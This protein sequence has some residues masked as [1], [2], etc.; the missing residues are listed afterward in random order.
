[1]SQAPTFKRSMASLTKGEAWFSVKRRE[2]M[3]DERLKIG[4]WFIQGRH[5]ETR[6]RSRTLHTADLS[7]ISSSP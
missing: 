5:E 6:K 2:G 3:K 4:R 1:M 7:L